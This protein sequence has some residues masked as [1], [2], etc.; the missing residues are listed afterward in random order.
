MPVN[1]PM[2]RIVKSNSIQVNPEF[3]PPSRLQDRL[4]EVR[5]NRHQP[6]KKSEDSMGWCC[7]VLVNMEFRCQVACRSFKAIPGFEEVMCLL[8]LIGVGV[9]TC[10]KTGVFTCSRR[11]FLLVLN[12]RGGREKLKMWVAVPYRQLTDLTMPARSPPAGCPYSFGN[13][14]TGFCHGAPAEKGK[15]SIGDGVAVGPP[16]TSPGPF[17]PL[18]A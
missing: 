10:L 8:R 14:D 7:Y 13:P 15:L 2:G 18:A 11:V 6:L 3:T 16:V 12:N 1:A 5:H 4:I 17:S 9:F